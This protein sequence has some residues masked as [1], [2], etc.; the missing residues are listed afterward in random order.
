M[1]SAFREVRRRTNVVGR[2]PGETAAL[3][4]IRA[5]LEQDRLKWRGPQMDEESRRHIIQTAKEASIEKHDVPV[6]HRHLEA[7]QDAV[8]YGLSDRV[9]PA[10][11]LHRPL[12]RE[13][14][15]RR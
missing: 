12:G 1:A 14:R 5:T 2:F 11:D 3:T 4:L 10:P 7:A 9:A 6:L 13:P 15:S 8:R